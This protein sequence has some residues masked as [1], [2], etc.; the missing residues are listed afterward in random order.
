MAAKAVKPL[1]KMNF[2]VRATVAQGG[3]QNNERRIK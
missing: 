1:M 3:W 2:G